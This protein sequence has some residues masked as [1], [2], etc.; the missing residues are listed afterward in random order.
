MGRAVS[1]REVVGSGFAGDRPEPTPSGRDGESPSFFSDL[2][3]E[4]ITSLADHVLS[5]VWIGG[6]DP[7]DPT[8]TWSPDLS[9]VQELHI[10]CSC[11]V[12][13]TFDRQG[14]EVTVNG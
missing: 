10:Q 11:G 6:C 7:V 14:E 1:L 5:H 9:A 2:S 13:R 3:D 4:Q 12:R 8:A